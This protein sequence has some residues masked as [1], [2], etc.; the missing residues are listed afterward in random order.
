M[1]R[2]A[3]WERRLFGRLLVVVGVLAALCASPAAAVEFSEMKTAEGRRVTVC[4]VKVKEEK[5]R[6]FLNDDKGQ[7]FKSFERLEHWLNERGQKLTFGMNAGMYQP[8]FS[9]QGLFVAEGRQVAPLNL[10]SG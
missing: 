4:R 8:D 10:A 6:L 2:M 3:R 1:A 7:P 5:L 9:A